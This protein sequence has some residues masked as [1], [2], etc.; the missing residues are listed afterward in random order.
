MCYCNKCSG[1]GCV[2]LCWD[3]L[4]FIFIL[5]FFNLLCQ[6]TD[7][8]MFMLHGTLYQYL[9]H[10]V[11]N[12]LCYHIQS[13]RQLVWSHDKC[14]LSNVHLRELAIELE[15]VEL[16]KECLLTVLYII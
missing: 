7:V 5:T 1:L 4:A 14:T 10:F 8:E 16:T 2:T 6:L 13:I 11:P 9:N 12:A 15:L 3:V